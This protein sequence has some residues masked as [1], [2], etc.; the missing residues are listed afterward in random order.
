MTEPG[1]ASLH[2]WLILPPI[3]IAAAVLVW[4]V[5]QAREPQRKPPQ[6]I[7]RVLSVIAAPA[8]D[9]VP[10]VL[11]YGTARPARVWRAVAEVEGRVVEVHPE[12]KAGAFIKA[13][14]V[15]LK[16]DPREYEL[17]VSQLEEAIAQDEASLAELDTQEEND[18]ASLDIEQ[19]SLELAKADL[20]RVR[21]LIEG[22]E[23]AP[24][25]V[26]DYERTY[27]AQKQK[28]QALHN[29]LSLV[30]K[31]RSQLQATIA[32]S[33]S[34]LQKAR[35]D[36][37]KTVIKAPF[38]CR[39]GEVQIEA[40]QYLKAGE[41]LFEA[42]GTDASEVDAHVSLDRTRGLLPPDLQHELGSIPSM[43]EL[44]KMFDIQATVR[45]HMG[46]FVATWPARF[47]RIREQIDPITRTAGVVVAVD[48]PY[49]RAIPGQRPPLVKGTYC[50]VELRGKTL[51]DRIVIPRVAMHEGT[52]Y[53][54]DEANRLARRDVTVQ[55]AQSDFL[56][57]L[58]GLEPGMRVVV[59][60][61][62]PAIEGMLVE[63]ANDE[64]LTALLIAEAQAGTD[65]R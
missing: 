5:R 2:K 35:L 12:L 1:R 24:T 39:L 22:N 51:P 7:A 65:V 9:V 28:V 59:S 8:V 38:Q 19:S 57:I 44:R 49:E 33:K 27:L 29:S 20:E 21:G 14:D 15:V 25:E 45:M 53:V 55:F 13:D 50:E 30:P 34:R 42:D 43:A 62:T 52:V 64:Q 61:P 10:R 26:R 37:Q 3:V 54:V 46:D 18:R 40:G 23:A 58:N 36:L 47:V 63:P 48:K 4:F 17:D 56:C 31:K 41:T 32:V 16:I 6:E 11:G 60:D